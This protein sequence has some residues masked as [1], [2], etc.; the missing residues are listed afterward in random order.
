MGS[1]AP[2]VRFR[3]TQLP[4]EAGY[5]RSAL[6]TRIRFGRI[7]HSSV[8]ERKNSHVALLILLACLLEFS[9]V[10]RDEWSRCRWCV[11]AKLEFNVSICLD[12]LF[13]LRVQQDHTPRSKFTLIQH[14]WYWYC[15]Y[16]IYSCIINAYVFIIHVLY[17]CIRE[18]KWF[19]YDLWLLLGQNLSQFNLNLLWNLILLQIR[20]DWLIDWSILLYVRTI[21]P[22]RG[23]PV[24]LLKNNFNL[25]VKRKWIQQTRCLT[26]CLLHMNGKVILHVDFIWHTWP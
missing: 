6:H 24:M 20:L 2:V 3:W 5:S 1:S 17:I 15:K 19:V 8:Y 26:V 21:S 18:G 23:S 16:C 13:V 4:W 25:T 7:S 14:C 9:S 11:D 12:I 22:S 10:H